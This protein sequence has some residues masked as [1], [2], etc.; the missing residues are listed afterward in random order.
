MS[1]TILTVIVLVVMWVVVLVPMVVRKDLLEETEEATAGGGDL[2]PARLLPRPLRAESPATVTEPI[3]YD[4]DAPAPAVATSGSRSRMLMRR[5]RTLAALATLVTLSAVA[6]L[7]LAAAWW[8]VQIGLDLM[9]TGYLVWLRA[10]VKRAA[11]RRQSR[12]VR[13]Q[14]GWTVDEVETPAVPVAVPRPPSPRTTVTAQIV[15]LDDD[16]PS[17]TDL[18]ERYPRAV[19]G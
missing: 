11:Q 7:T 2:T 15:P 14:A 18:E 17:F 19:N 5:R 12:E 4:D 8:I 1:S 9:L 16:D 13:M 10:E 6:A 3:H